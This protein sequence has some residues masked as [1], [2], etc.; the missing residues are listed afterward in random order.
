M[1]RVATAEY[2]LAVLYPKIA[3]QWDYVENG[4]KKPEDFLPG[5]GKKVTWNCL[6]K[7]CKHKWSTAISNRISSHGCP[8]CARR[9]ATEEYNLAVTHPNI[10]AEWHP[11]ANRS[12][13]PRDITCG[14]DTRVIWQCKVN[15]VHKWETALNDRTR[16]RSG[17]PSCIRH[18]YSKAAIEWLDYI[19]KRTGLHI[20]HAE[21]GG[22]MKIQLQNGKKISVDGFCKETH[23][24][25]EFHRT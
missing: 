5:S 16:G 7:R 4:G 12:I 14:S 9:V 20:Q 22:E 18:G 24:V 6:Q 1:K 17:C 25:F 2:N 23:T 15:L 3:E 10:A 11:T 19:A 13:T 21:N 8:N